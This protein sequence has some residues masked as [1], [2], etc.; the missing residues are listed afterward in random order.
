M[1]PDSGTAAARSA[2]GQRRRRCAHD[3]GPAVRR[4]SGPSRP[5]EQLTE[6]TRVSSRCCRGESLQSPSGTMP[7]TVGSS[8]PSRH[9]PEAA[10]VRA[11]QSPGY[12][13]HLVRRG[14]ALKNKTV[15]LVGAIKG[16]EQRV[17]RAS[18]TR[19]DTRWAMTSLYEDANTEAS[20]RRG[21]A[22]PVRG[23]RRTRLRRAAYVCGSR[24]STAAYR[25]GARQNDNRELVAEGT[26]QRQAARTYTA[27]RAAAGDRTR[28]AFFNGPLDNPGLDVLAC[29]EPGRQAGVEVTGTVK[30][31]V[32]RLTSNPPVP[33]NEKARMAGPRPPGLDNAPPAPIRSRCRRLSRRSPS[34]AS[35]SD[36]TCG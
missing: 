25:Q 18:A 4:L 16:A 11:L 17:L 1:S 30:V 33:D 31:P 10:E 32:V 2:L 21:A 8:A 34:E 7:A 14:H 6:V 5:S 27:F 26:I 15:T 28:Q 36:N 24:V 29:A 3:R 35:R 19:P 22:H 20:R 23:R 13:A 12:A 9:H